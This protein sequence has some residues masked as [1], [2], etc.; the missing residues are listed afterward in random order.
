MKILKANVKLWMIT[1]WGIAFAVYTA[2]FIQE[3]FYAPQLD[4][5]RRIIV[6]ASLLVG[7]M[8][9]VIGGKLI[10]NYNRQSGKA[11]QNSSQNAP[12]PI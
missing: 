12:V 11:R 3:N 9:G 5:T 2:V 10:S 7:A 8:F 4:L 1:V 6:S